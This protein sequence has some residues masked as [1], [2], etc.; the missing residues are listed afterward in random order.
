MSP[1]NV[2]DKIYFK[3][4]NSGDLK[5]LCFWTLESLELS[6]GEMIN[7][8]ILLICRKFN[9]QFNQPPSIQTPLSI[10][11]SQDNLQPIQLVN[12]RLL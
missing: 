11:V 9:V 4:F 2:C 1:K 3:M 7:Y 12:K 5:Q 6:Y 10:A 8:N